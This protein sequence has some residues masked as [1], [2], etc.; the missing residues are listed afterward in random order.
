MPDAKS[1][2]KPMM[3]SHKSQNVQMENVSQFADFD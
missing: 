2:S 3:T 1:L